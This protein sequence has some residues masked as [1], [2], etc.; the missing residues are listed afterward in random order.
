MIGID[1]IDGMQRVGMFERFCGKLESYV[2]DSCLGC[3]CCG[4]R[5]DEWDVRG[6]YMGETV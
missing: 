6:V 3:C 4:R 5:V 2:E 1:E